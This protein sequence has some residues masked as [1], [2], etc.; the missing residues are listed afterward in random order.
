MKMGVWQSDVL[1]FMENKAAHATMGTPT[2][3]DI[4]KIYTMLF[5]LTC[6]AGKLAHCTVNTCHSP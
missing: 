4:I 6:A 1:V 2:V 5:R 3:P